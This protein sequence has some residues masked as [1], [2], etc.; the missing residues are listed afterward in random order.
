MGGKTKIA[1]SSVGFQPLK[2]VFHIYEE[3]N[4]ASILGTQ[5]DHETL[6]DDNGNK[7]TIVG[8]Y[9]EQNLARQIFPYGVLCSQFFETR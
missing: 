6:K 9:I 2:V 1:F 3:I 5:I 7:L 4:F 8:R